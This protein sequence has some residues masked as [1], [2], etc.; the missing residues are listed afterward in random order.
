MEERKT[1]KQY[2]KEAKRRLKN[3]FWQNYEKNLEEKISMAK[4]A[5]VSPS[6]VKEYYADMISENIKSN[7]DEDEEFYRKVKK[8][9]DEE[10]EIYNAIG[11]LTDKA[12]Y[13]ALSYEEKQRYNL[14]LSE[15][16]LK[17]VAR[18][19]KEKSL[20]FSENSAR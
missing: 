15:K 18:Y 17:A 3:G 1:L 14:S 2:A 4:E 9:L 13:D 11:R 16:Y 8:I 5:G 20:S 7:K 10:G 19:E 6:K 12:V